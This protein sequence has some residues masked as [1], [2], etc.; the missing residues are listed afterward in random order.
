MK[1]E[2]PAR[3]ANKFLRKNN[4]HWGTSDFQ[5]ES[6]KFLKEIAAGLK[7]DEGSSL[8]M[9]PSYLD[10]GKIPV[11]RKQ[12]IAADA[13]G[14][15]FRKAVVTFDDEAITIEELTRHKMP[16]S[17]GAEIE[18]DEFFGIIAGFLEPVILKS[19]RIGFCFSYPARI[20][21][22]K[23][24]VMIS[25]T[26]E[27]KVKDIEGIKVAE[28]LNYKLRKP[29]NI[30]VLNDTVAGLLGGVATHWGAG[31][32]DFICLILGTGMNVCYI[33]NNCEILKEDDL[34]NKPGFTII[35]LESG[36]YDK[37]PRGSAD[38]RLDE[39]TE[40]PGKQLTEKMLSG[41]Y[42]GDLVLEILRLAAEE[43]CFKSVSKDDLRELE[44][45]Q[46]ADVLD[47][48]DFPDNEKGILNK[49]FKDIEDRRFA[50]EVIKNLLERSARYIAASICA[51]LMKTG[52]GK[53]PHKP[54]CLIVE[55]TTFYA[56]SKYQKIFD[57]Y[58][59]M[60]KDEFGFHVKRVKVENGALIGAAFS[61]LL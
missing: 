26:K 44:T 14:T 45:L 16:G 35:N 28:A 22:D 36:A 37:F 58:L 11:S 20:L 31:Y 12:V 24:A 50:H 13:G 49:F 51:I 27:V 54:V 21:P 61:T 57:N 1:N 41:A 38:M 40:N 5:E 56:S 39:K 6:I 2:D 4:M 17:N 33:E 3:G 30:T 60:I 43:S 7:S 46:T 55:G 48:F 47:F 19:D 23:E 9:I 59:K 29:K 15:N 53:N 34:K 32:D 52:K 25:M 42:L 18:R 8:K 10:P